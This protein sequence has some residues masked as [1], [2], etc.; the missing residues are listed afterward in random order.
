MAQGTEIIFQ[1]S[2]PG[3][4]LDEEAQQIQELFADRGASRGEP[5]LTFFEP[6]KLAEQVREAGFAEV[7]G[8][9]SGGGQCALLCQSCRRPSDDS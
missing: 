8:L 3:A 9:R 6:A 4:L 7:W 2:P 1:Y 5:Y